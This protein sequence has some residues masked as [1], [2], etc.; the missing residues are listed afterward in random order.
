M[1]VPT[2]HTSQTIGALFAAAVAIDPARPLLTYYD[3]ASGERTELSGATLDNWVAKTANLL[4]DGYGLGPGDRAAVLLPPHWQSAAVL[5]GC[6]SAGLAVVGDSGPDVVSAA[7]DVAFAA[8][9]VV[10]A[11]VDRAGEAP[12]AGDRLALG[13]APMAL[14]LRSVPDGFADYVI[15]VRAHGDRYIGAPVPP[16]TPAL[17]SA[18]QS[19]LCGLAVSRAAALGLGSGD[20]VLIDAAAHPDPVDWLL[21]PLAAGATIVLCVHLDPAAVESRRAS[22]RITR[23]LPPISA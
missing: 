10:F 19:E 12:A 18:T 23:D 5:L 17:D 2:E 14:P 6:W 16:T 15:T 21:A 8:V 22:E 1:G 7:V 20:R 3:D 4:V 11:A 9:D 13:L